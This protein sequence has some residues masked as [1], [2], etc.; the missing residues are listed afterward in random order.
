MISSFRRGAAFPALLLVG[1]LTAGGVAATRSTA[2]EARVVPP[3]AVDE[4]AGGNASEVAVIAGGCFWGVQGVFQHVAG[5]TS[6]VSGYAGGDK[7]TAHYEMTSEGN[8][9]P[10]GI[11]PDHLRSA[12][13]HLRAHPAG[14][15]L[16]RA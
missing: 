10:R 12:Q 1:L 15:F 2:E 11:G 3:P 5:V 14:L 13:D 8:D 16:G 7:A 4:Q 9:R 6:A